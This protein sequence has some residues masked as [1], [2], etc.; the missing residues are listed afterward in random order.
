[1]KSLSL[2]EAQGH[3]VVPVDYFYNNDLEYLKGESS[4]RKYTTSTTKAK[5]AEYDNIKGIE[6]MILA[7]WSPVKVAYNKFA[8]RGIS[9]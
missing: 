8:M 7:L 1:S 2:I 4:S 5:A 6:D 3:Q 9:H